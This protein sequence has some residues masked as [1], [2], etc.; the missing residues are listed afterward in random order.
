VT[1]RPALYESGTAELDDDE[2]V[3][4]F[5]TP[6]LAN[7]RFRHYD[8][9]RLAW[10]YLRRASCEAATERMVAGIRR[11][12][13][14]HHGDLSKYHDTITRAFMRLVAAHVALTPHE[15]DFTIFAAANPELFDKRLLLVYYSE[16]QLMSGAARAGWMAPDRRQLP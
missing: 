1:G 16:Q 8:H 12:A 3:I 2:F 13:L 6:T 7:E 11:F 10:I 15:S 4:A 9:V 5:E 14:H